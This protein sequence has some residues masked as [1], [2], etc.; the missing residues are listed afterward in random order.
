MRKPT[1]PP[2]DI[3]PIMTPAETTQP[4]YPDLSTVIP[5]KDSDV[6]QEAQNFRL[7]QIR[8]IRDNLEKEA[9]TRGR[10]RRRYKALYNT[11]YYINFGSSLTSVASSTVAVVSLSTVVG[12]LP[13]LPFGIVAITT[14]VLGVVSS[15]VSKLILKKTEKHE[16]I[17]LIALSKLSS[18]NDL[19]S[20][21]L[22]N[23]KISD[24]EFQVILNEMESYRDHKSQIRTGVRNQ[25][26]NEREQEIR[27]EAE[28]KGLKKGQAIAMS[29]LQNILKGTDR[30]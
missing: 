20:R 25:L 23:G 14:G 18:V 4:I 12:A 1:A 24:E 16:R 6:N 9:E 30:A 11:A 29:N 2:E 10:L 3:H 15:K 5:V 26:S 17:K 22:T 27:D 19:V 21:A 13:A 28:K 8:D 7:K